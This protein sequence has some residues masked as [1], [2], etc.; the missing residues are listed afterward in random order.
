MT[1]IDFWNLAG[2]A[3]RQGKEFQG[4]IICIDT[5]HTNVCKTSVPFERKKIFN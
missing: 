5:E 3:G 2:R 1:E 4:N